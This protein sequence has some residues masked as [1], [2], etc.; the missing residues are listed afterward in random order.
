MNFIEAFYTL[1]II[2]NG[3]KFSFKPIAKLHTEKIQFIN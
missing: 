3:E 2:V 1:M